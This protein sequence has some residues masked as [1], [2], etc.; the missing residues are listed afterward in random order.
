[1]VATR[2]KALVIVESPAKARKIGGYLGKDYDVRASMG[3][4]RDLPE[5]ASEIPEEIKKEP[6]SRLG[7]NPNDRFTPVYVINP[8]K[9]KVITELKTL[10]KGA[11]ELILATDEDREGESIGWHLADILQPKV[12]VK[13]MV[14]SEITK[15]AIVEA[16]ESH[17]RTGHEPG[18]GPGDPPG[19]RPAVWLHAQPAAVE[20][21]PPRPLR[22]ARAKRRRAGSG[23]A[24]AGTA[25]VPERHVLGSEGATRNDAAGRI[26]R[27]SSTTVGGKR[28]ATGKDFDE[29]TGQA[30]G[31]DR[32]PAA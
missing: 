12:P 2:K 31:R 27:R 28:I 15:K 9:K 6:W 24:R 32:R 3:H 26:S 14:F 21:D 8:D 13:R 5:D 11:D 25:G 23:A 20:K 4:V 16:I 17:P 18:P 29:H 19:P 10:L 1:M 7:V 22:R 30:R